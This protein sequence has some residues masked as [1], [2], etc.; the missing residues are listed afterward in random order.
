M[1]TK[2]IDFYASRVNKL[3]IVMVNRERQLFKN[4]KVVQAIP[5]DNAILQFKGYL[6]QS[7]NMA[8]NTTTKQVCTVLIGHNAS[9]FNTP[10]LLRNPGK[11]FIT[12]FQS[13]DVWFADSL[14]LFK[15]LIISQL[16]ALKNTDGTL[17]KTNQSSIYRTLF[18]QT[19]D[20]HDA[21]EDVLALR[22]ILF[23]SK[24][25]LSSKLIIENSSLV[26]ANHAFEDVVYLD[27]RHKKLQ[28]FQ[29]K[30]FDAE[31][32]D[33]VIKKSI[34]EKIA[35]SGLAYEDLMR[36][37]SRYGKE[38]LTANLLR[39]PSCSNQA[40]ESVALFEF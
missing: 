23:P 29:G 26:D 27:G 13:M 3:K 20:A 22:R 5:F 32:N 33:G 35:G 12:V 31:R 4:N 14:S 37:Y 15:E 30:L 2:D 34:P 18:N 40:H 7:I 10:I 28:S 9:S 19:F 16:P 39:P 25:E 24:L 17:P 1:P 21:L 6:L 11:E 36:V 8:K 38:G